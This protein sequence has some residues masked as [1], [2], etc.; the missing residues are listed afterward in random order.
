QDDLKGLEKEKRK[1][2]KT[3]A[4]L[5]AVSLEPDIPDEDLTRLIVRM[6]SHYRDNHA[7]IN[8]MI[9]VCMLG[10]ASIFL[11]GTLASLEFFQ[12]TSTSLTFTIGPGILLLP[13]LLITTAIAIVSLISSIYFH[14]FAK[15]WD[16]RIDEIDHSAALLKQTLENDGQ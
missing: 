3:N 8:R 5:R 4:Q 7:T 6:L 16:E 2:R 11:L 14:R 15:V 13:S 10:S 9:Y 12:L 1:E